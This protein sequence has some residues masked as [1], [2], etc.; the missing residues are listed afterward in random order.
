MP[1]LKTHRIATLLA[2]AVAAATLILTP[3]LA[4][5]EEEAPPT[6]AA[7]EE[8]P[9]PPPAQLGRSDTFVTGTWELAVDQVFSA[10]S[11]IRN[12]YTEVRV[13]LTMR[14]IGDAE[15]VYHADGFF[16]AAGYPRLDL[17]DGAGNAGPLRGSHSTRALLPGSMLSTVPPG[18]TARWT[19]GFQVPSAF[20]D[21]LTLNVHGAEG[22]AA[23]DLS[24]AVGPAQIGAPEG[25]ATISL[26]E[27]VDWGEDFALSAFDFGTLMCGDPNRQLAMQIVAVG[28]E[29]GNKTGLDADWP[30]VRFP[31][32]VAVA[33]WP[34]GASARF[35]FETFAGDFEPLFKWSEDAARFPAGGN[36]DEP[37]ATYRRA[38]LFAVPRDGRLVDADAGPVGL[39]LQPPGSDSALWLDLPSAGGLAIGPTLC[40]EGNLSFTIPFSF[41]P[42]VDFAVGSVPADADPAAQDVAAKKLLSEVI[43]VA[44]NYRSDNGGS[45]EGMTA[46]TLSAMWD[47]VVL[48]AGFIAEV[49]KVGV[50]TTVDEGGETTAILVTQSGSGEYFCLADGPA[51]LVQ[52]QE[53]TLEDITEA[54]VPLVVEE[55]ADTTTTTTTVPGV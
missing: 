4:Q 32:N 48:Q 6:T 19:I 8:V 46:G 7:A 29:V 28:F 36:D 50:S 49:G 53:S 45:Y 22:D 16:G 26:G 27:G 52:A 54:C 12:G 40:D 37:S 18:L 39:W 35:A 17:T 10:P 31:D 38:M 43:V 24:S 3:A 1:R 42:G 21:T 23:F 34:D 41:G 2:L 30:G 47:R 51:G 13:G 20:T 33:V 15:A 55:T 9:L 5:S 11:P 44:G 14:N 25:V